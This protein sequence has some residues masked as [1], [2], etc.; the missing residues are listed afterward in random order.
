M[1]ATIFAFLSFFSSSGNTVADSANIFLADSIKRPGKNIRYDTLG[2]G[3]FLTVN[4]IFII[5]NRITRDQII[6]RELSLKKGD[7]VYSTD[8]PGILDK[9]KKKLVNTR[10]FNK[11]EIRTMEAGAGKI[12]ILIDLN[13]RWYTFP[14]PV[15]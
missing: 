10:L 15:F 13:E 3:K 8:I 1:L 6:L 5:G 2:N 12:D 14:A 11:V 7:I 4:R 9:D